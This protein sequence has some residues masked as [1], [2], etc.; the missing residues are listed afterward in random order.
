[1]RKIIFTLTII[2]AG[3]MAQAEEAAVLKNAGNDALIA[4][5]Y[6]TALAKYEAYF[7]SGEEGV[8]NDKKTIYNA[9]RCAYKVKKYDQAMGYYQKCIDL[10]YRADNATYYTAILYK[11]QDNEEKYLATLEEG[12]EKYPGSKIKKNFLKGVT[13]YYNGLASKPYNE[14][15]SLA[16]AAA[17]SGDPSIYLS[18]MKQA[19]GLFDQAKTAFEKTLEFDATNQVATSAIASIKDQ[20]DSYNTYK[21]SLN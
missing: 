11:K 20:I 4:K 17:V 5:D 14:A 13:G 2:A 3:F 8:A 15:N 6:P 7:A 9:A 10:N 18:K 19:L 21:A 1:M 16:T 12:L